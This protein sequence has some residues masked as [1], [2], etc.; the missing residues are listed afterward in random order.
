MKEDTETYKAALNS[1]VAG[2]V[3]THVITRRPMVVLSTIPLPLAKA[4]PIIAPTPMMDVE[5]GSP[6]PK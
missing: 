3:N 5:T 6:Y 2:R 1:I 4:E